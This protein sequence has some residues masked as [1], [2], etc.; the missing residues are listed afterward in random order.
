MTLRM[1]REA[2]ARLNSKAKGKGSLGQ[3]AITF[4]SFGVGQ[5]IP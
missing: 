4:V 5:Q 2:L 1:K 3:F